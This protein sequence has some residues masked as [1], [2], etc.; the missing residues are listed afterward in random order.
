MTPF[1]HDH[2]IVGL[3]SIVVANQI[4]F[5]YLSWAEHLR[6]IGF[7]VV[8]KVF[9]WLVKI[10]VRL[11]PIQQFFHVAW[12][13]FDVCKFKLAILKVSA[14]PAF[15]DELEPAVRQVSDVFRAAVEGRDCSSDHK[16][17]FCTELRVEGVEVLP[18]VDQ[19]SE[20]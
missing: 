17:I 16:A 7:Y 9:R 1:E 5:V 2:E 18:V 20:I 4:Q 3:L 19:H 8:H 13:S 12:L 11:T 15:H 6:A 14:V 10:R